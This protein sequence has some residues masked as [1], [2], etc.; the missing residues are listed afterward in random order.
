MQK[1]GFLKMRHYVRFWQIRSQIA[2]LYIAITVYVFIG[3]YLWIKQEQL[4][5]SCYHLQCL[6]PLY[7][8]SVYRIKLALC[9]PSFVRE[10]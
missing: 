4:N 5:V 8:V 1:S 6:S 7:K 10:S 9:H 2:Y 3:I